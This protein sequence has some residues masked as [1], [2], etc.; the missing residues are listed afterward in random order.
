M[1]KQHLC[2]LTGFIIAAFLITSCTAPITLTSWKNPED[3]TKVSKVV[4]MALFGKL[5]YT[6]PVEQYVSAYFR[7][8]GLKSI[9]ALDFL[10]P[11]KKYPEAEIKSKLDSLG[12]DAIL[13]FTYKGTDVSQNYVPATYYGYA[14]GPWGYGYG[15][16]Y[17]WGGGVSTGGYWTT[18]KIVNIKAS[19]YSTSV[20]RSKGALWTADIT[21]TDPSYIDQAATNVAQQIY[22]DWQKNQV[23][24]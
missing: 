17:G 15:Y 11:T 20:Q 1:K 18:T 13:V 3:N 21:I 19:L 5:E 23:L 24:K 14:G 2:F 9:E 12:A 16:Y 4:V 10:D 7:S 8:R 6:K 22:M